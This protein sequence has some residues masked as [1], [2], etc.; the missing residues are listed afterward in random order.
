MNL[1]LADFILLFHALYVGVV[2]CSV[3][4]IMIGGWCGWRWVRSPLYRFIHLA[5]IGIVVVEV[6]IGMACPL[7]IWEKALRAQPGSGE[8]PG[9]IAHWVGRALF[10][11][12]PQWVFNTA[13][14]AFGLLVLSLF[15]FVPVRRSAVA[16]P[17][18]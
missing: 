13:Y 5:M 18:S 15:Y 4:L 10:H 1:L 7:T 11:H 14:I 3:P 8:E 9:F 2:V 12:Y 16:K 17:Q 6:F